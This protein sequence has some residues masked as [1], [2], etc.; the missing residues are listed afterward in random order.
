MPTDRIFN[1]KNMARG[2]RDL[3]HVRIDSTS[4]GDV[5]FRPYLT[6]V[7]FFLLPELRDFRLSNQVTVQVP[8]SS[9]VPCIFKDFVHIWS[10]RGYQNR[11]RIKAKANIRPLFFLYSRSHSL[12]HFASNITCLNS[13]TSKYIKKQKFFT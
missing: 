8:N 3:Y 9:K 12:S 5:N 13:K 2:I 7:L 6:S 4:K 1:R 11:A 10:G